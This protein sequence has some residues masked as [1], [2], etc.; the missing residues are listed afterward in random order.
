MVHVH[1]DSNHSHSYYLN[2]YIELN[3][4]EWN[5]NHFISFN[6][7]NSLNMTNFPICHENGLIR[8]QQQGNIVEYSFISFVRSYI[9]KLSKW[10]LYFPLCYR[11]KGYCC[12][13]AMLMTTVGESNLWKLADAE[14]FPYFIRVPMPNIPK[15]YMY[16]IAFFSHGCRWPQKFYPRNGK[17]ASTRL[18]YELTGTPKWIKFNFVNKLF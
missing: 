9:Y 16:N 11:E 12:S 7:F 18:F 10:N 4:T 3:A 14:H 15:T 17:L 1:K 13:L 5:P 8:Q 2:L 6:S